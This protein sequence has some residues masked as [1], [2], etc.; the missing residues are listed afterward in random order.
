M[1]H[2]LKKKKTHF[3]GG[4]SIRTIYSPGPFCFIIFLEI[5]MPT[6]IAK[7][8]Q[9]QENII[10]NPLHMV[11]KKIPPSW[12]YSITTWTRWK[13]KE[14][15]NKYKTNMSPNLKYVLITMENPWELVLFFWLWCAL[16]WCWNCLDSIWSWE[17][18]P[19]FWNEMVYI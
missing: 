2:K 14:A 4:W 11:S 12:I 17:T 16:F 19:V 8:W 15:W 10:S 18:S 5:L 6:S 9:L 1:L 7:L 3:L 13:K